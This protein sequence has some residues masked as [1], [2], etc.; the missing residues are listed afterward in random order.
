[1]LYVHVRTK[2]LLGMVWVIMLAIHKRLPRVKDVCIFC[3]TLF[4]LLKI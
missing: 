4:I 2:L 1:M 3:C